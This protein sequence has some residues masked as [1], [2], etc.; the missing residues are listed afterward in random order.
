LELKNPAAASLSLTI[1]HNIVAFRDLMSPPSASFFVASLTS[2][3]E[4]V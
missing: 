4:T 2:F 3:C 1:I